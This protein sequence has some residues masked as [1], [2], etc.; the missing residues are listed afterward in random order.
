MPLAEG[1]AVEIVNILGQ[2]LNHF[3]QIINITVQ[4]AFRCE[5]GSFSLRSKIA[6]REIFRGERVLN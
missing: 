1:K 4:I 5:T 6:Q 3:Y 2:K